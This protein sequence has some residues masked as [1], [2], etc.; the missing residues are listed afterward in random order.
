MRSRL[1]GGLLAA[2]AMFLATGAV[3]AYAQTPR[4][5]AE[6]WQIDGIVAALKDPILEVRT[7]ALLYVQSNSEF[8][9]DGVP[10]PLIAS[11]LN[12]PNVRRV[13]S[14]LK[15]NDDNVQ[16]GTDTAADI[17]MPRSQD[18][19]IALLENQN[20]SFAV[21]KAVALVLC[22]T[23][24]PQE[25]HALITQ[26]RVKQ[27]RSVLVKSLVV[28]GP[29]NFKTLPDLTYPF[30]YSYED[31]PEYRFL[32]HYLLG[33]NDK[34][35]LVLKHTFFEEGEDKVKAADYS[36]IDDA[37]KA[38][39]AFDAVLPIN[40][41]NTGFQAEIEKQIL[42]IAHKWKDEWT[43]KDYE[44]LN[45]LS[46]KMNEDS[47]AAL[48]NIIKQ[49]YWTRLLQ[50]LWKVIAVQIAFWILLLYFYPRSRAVQAFFFWN[51]WARK[52]FGLGYVDLC[53]TWIP[54]LRNRLL[55]PFREELV[56]EARVSDEDLNDY[57][58]DIEVRQGESHISLFHAIPEIFGQ[59]ILESESGLGKSIFLR[60]LV[61]MSKRT[62]AYL[63]AENCDR[64]V[65]ELIQLKLKGK[66]S[67]ETFL[68][69]IIWAG[70]LSIVIDGLNEVTV[71]TREKIRRFVDDFPKANILL[72]TQ[73]LFWKRPP[74]ALVFRIS[75]LT[76]DRIQAFLESRYRTFVSPLIMTESAYKQRCRD[77]LEDV[78]GNCQSEEDKTAARLVLSN[79]MDLTVAAQILVAG[80]TPT[81][82]NLQEQQFTRVDRDFRDIRHGEQ[83]PL[84][85]FSESVYERLLGDEITLDSSQF[86]EAIQ[87]LS[88]HKMVLMQN[89]I[90]ADQ[91][92]VRRWVFR[93][94]KIRDFF[95]V[96]AFENDHGNRIGEHIED[97]RFRGVYLMLAS[98]LPLAEANE[99]RDALV[100]RAAETKDH[101]LSDA[102]VEVLKSRRVAGSRPV[103]QR[104]PA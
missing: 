39:E 19:Q 27:L 54:Y 83:F 41:R 11:L 2:V 49:P 21:R 63:A 72:A 88:S 56:A 98:Q 47:R 103:T 85:Q 82:R 10:D 70:G 34:A 74:K 31:L 86:F 35:E 96:K 17:T 61:S 18:D 73:P 12:D 69:S 16:S 66:A 36:D 94:D 75:P 25:E 80:D 24:S 5:A 67:D 28:H 93:H 60:R 8:T 89:E 84:R 42:F 51:R 99:L 81:L 64:G 101:H 32:I 78:L 1:Q 3:C 58:H 30:Y 23:P 92:P 68:R 95:L 100:D 29:L 22:T 53:L 44:L 57:F 97:P 13:I 38:L 77:Y 50:K 65:F 45:S 33:G 4:K 43:S 52:F 7:H 9:W 40:T 87:V 55:G 37:R 48:N 20:V 71:E 26:L 76:D 14:S 91:R 62:N 6:K 102:V 79:P 59:S 90:D 46:F 15:A 104:T